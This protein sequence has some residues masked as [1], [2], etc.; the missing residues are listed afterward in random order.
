[1]ADPSHGAV[2]AVH[3]DLAAVDT[4][5][6]CGNFACASCLVPRPSG[7]PVC[8]T[9]AEREPHELLPWD[10]RQNLG[11]FKAYWKTCWRLMMAPSAFGR[12]PREGSVSSSMVFALLSAIVGISTTALAYAAIF[13]V[14]ASF[15]A[16]GANGD[17]P[18]AWAGVGLGVGMFVGMVA[19]TWVLT[20]VMASLDHL[21]LKL[22]GAQPQEWAVSYR[23][24][25]LSMAPYIIGVVPICG[26]Y[27]FPIWAVVLKVFA[28]RAFHRTT[29]GK[30]A[31][32][33]LGAPLVLGCCCGGGY[34]AFIFAAVTSGTLH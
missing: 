11:L 9:C 30:A 34:V 3:P 8:S 6:R 2:C 19:I 14:A 13:A 17:F 26:A 7:G 20:F 10:D 22:V 32:G 28:Y 4:C 33:A 21:V 15:A 1:M 27:V 25:C 12:S 18:L 16:P 23:A 5:S 29:G 31:A 24:T